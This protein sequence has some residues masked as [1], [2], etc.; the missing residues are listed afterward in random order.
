M[1][2]DKKTLDDTTAHAVTMTCLALAAEAPGNDVRP[3]IA[4]MMTAVCALVILES[5]NSGEQPYQIKKRLLKLANAAFYNSATFVDS[6]MT[7]M[8][9]EED[10][11]I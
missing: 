1:D 9:A 10:R 5:R 8:A 7:A 2:P 11:A 4:G 3:V 6:I